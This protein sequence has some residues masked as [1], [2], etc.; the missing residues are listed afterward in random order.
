MEVLIGK[1]ERPWAKIDR[2]SGMRSR[3]HAAHSREGASLG[4]FVG[5]NAGQAGDVALTGNLV[6]VRW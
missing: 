1:D 2:L 5:P 4:G 3:R 6:L